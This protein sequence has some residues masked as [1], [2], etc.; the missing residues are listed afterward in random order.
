MTFFASEPPKLGRR[1][2]K[3]PPQERL[4]HLKKPSAAPVAGGNLTVPGG[5]QAYEPPKMDKPLPSVHE[6]PGPAP[7]P[8][9][10][11][12]GTGTGPVNG[13]GHRQSEYTPPINS[14]PPSSLFPG[15]P[16]TSPLQQPSNSSSFS[17]PGHHSR[18]SLSN[19]YDF[20]QPPPH[21]GHSP[22][23]LSHSPPRQNP[24]L[25]EPPPPRDSRPSFFPSPNIVVDS[26]PPAPSPYNY[27]TSNDGSGYSSPQRN[28]PRHSPP[29]LPPPSISTG[30]PSFPS[31]SAQRPPPNFYPPQPTSSPYPPPESNYPPSQPGYPQPQSAYSPPSQP[32]Y[33]VPGPPQFP[34][35][36]PTFHV[37]PQYTTYGHIPPPTGPGQRPFFVREDSVDEFP[38]PALAQRYSSPLPLPSKKK[39]PRGSS[40]FPVPTISPPQH[41]VPNTYSPNAEY[42]RENQWRREQ[43]E[44]DEE[45]ARRLDL[46]LNLGG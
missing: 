24:Y 5:A 9:T 28:S 29:Q 17:I 32:G 20:S 11:R 46:E 2:S 34:S 44:R 35:H 31:V 36:Y 42:E 15:R 22:P 3:L 37:Q 27:N 40:P 16:L 6:S 30:A 39:P 7:L 13:Q 25:S 33:P 14:P 18:P 41:P 8:P 19:G 23:R 43:E 45:I 26:T 4:Q 12:P 38:D 1:P 10:L 21:P